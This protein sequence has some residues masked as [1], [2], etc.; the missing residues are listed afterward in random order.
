[1]SSYTRLLKL[2]FERRT[3]TATDPISLRAYAGLRSTAPRRGTR[4]PVVDPFAL[5]SAARAAASADDHHLVGGLHA[6]AVV[7]GL[8]VD[9]VVATVILD[10][11]TKCGDV[12]SSRRMFDAMP[13][14][15]IVSWNAMISG[16]ANAGWA[17][18]EYTVASGLTACWG[19]S[20]LWTGAQIHGYAAR[21][22]FETD[23]AVVSALANM[24]F[25]CGDVES[26]QRAMEGREISCSS[27]EL[28]MIK[29]YVANGRYSDAPELV[30]RVGKQV[31]G[32]IVALGTG[33]YGSLCTG[34]NAVLWSCHGSSIHAQA[35][36][37]GIQDG[38]NSVVIETTLVDMLSERRGGSK[39]LMGSLDRAK[40]KLQLVLWM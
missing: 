16:Y 40:S 18:I 10:S 14:R 4:I 26:A 34:D 24:F 29:G 19:I 11:C 21:A 28:M 27:S 36:R 32:H 25:R 1:M 2:R 37:T 15:N 35:L 30:V 31:H 5:S 7:C 9:V 13:H 39:V 38:H 6:V 8:Y 20:D 22:G 12:H 3:L 23:R 17:L 33:E